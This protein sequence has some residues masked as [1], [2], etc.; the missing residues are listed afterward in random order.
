MFQ[1]KAYFSEKQIIQVRGY[2]VLKY[3]VANVKIWCSSWVKYMYMEVVSTC[4]PVSLIAVH[5]LIKILKF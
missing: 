3:F 4:M 5:V 1:K 2:I